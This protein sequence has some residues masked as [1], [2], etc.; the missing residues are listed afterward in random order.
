MRIRH[1]RALLVKV[2]LL[3]IILLLGGLALFGCTGVSTVPKGWSGGTMADGTL[4]VGSMEGEL[5]SINTSD[6]S[7]LWA[8]PLKASESSGGGFGCAPAS[9]VV[10]IY[11]SPAVGGDLVYVGGYNGKIYAITS[12]TGALRWVYPRQQYLKP[13]VGG[14]VVALGNIYFASADGKVYA[15]S[16]ETGDDKVWEQPFETGDKIWSTP[17][18]YGDT[19]FIGS[20]D[21]KL[22]AID[23]T[24]GK[25][26]WAKPFETQGAIASTPVVYNNTVYIGSFDR[27]LYAV[28]VTDGKPIWKFPA[29]EEDESKPGNWFWAKPVIYNDTVYAANLDGKVYILNA[30]TG[31]EVVD[32]IDLESPKIIL[33]NIKKPVPVSSSLVLAG[34]SVIAATENGVVY[35]LDSE[36]KAKRELVNLQENPAVKVQ[37][38]LVTDGKV[39][40][41]HTSTGKLHA[42]DAQ[43][44]KELWPPLSLKS[45]LPPSSPGT[46]NWGFL[47]AIAV[48]SIILVMAMSALRKRRKA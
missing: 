44:G 30:E 48:I 8:E 25:E 15:L 31:G 47:I 28:N 9:T 11:G 16:A 7:R 36:S 1:S 26:K 14:P 27:H 46:T 20:F 39:V 21:K 38:P 32:A 37:A 29:N 18:I 4:V 24:T 43:L 45:A 34:S 10:A 42:L 40:Y 19:L 2:S 5:V 12:K 17:A 23:T 22:Y 35:T 13:I 3:V 6:G 33:G 41:V